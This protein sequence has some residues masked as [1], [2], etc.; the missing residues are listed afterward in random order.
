MATPNRASLISKTYK[1]LKKHYKPVSTDTT[2]PLMEQLIFAACLENAHWAPAEEAFTALRGSFFDWNEV[3]VS[4]TR[5]L[6]EAMRMLPA[7]TAAATHV[8]QILQ[9]VFESAYAFE[10]EGL[11]K[12]NLGQAQQRLKKFEGVTPFSLAFVTQASLGGHSIA[13][14]RGTAGALA[15]VGLATQDEGESCAVAGLERAIPKSKGVEFGSLIHQLGADFAANPYSTN[16][17]KILLDI[18]PEAKER[19]PSRRAAKAAA[20]A[21]AAAAAERAARRAKREAAKKQPPP[22]ATKR[23]SS[24]EKEREARPAKPVVK[25]HEPRTGIAKRKPR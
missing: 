1:V 17:H 7:P 21:A 6:G 16:L 9:S 3:R 13:V 18:A 15:G 11:K 25:G 4:T 12:Q 23:A 5:E 20:E 14:D 19:L 8:K 24:K 10:L 2:R 22:P